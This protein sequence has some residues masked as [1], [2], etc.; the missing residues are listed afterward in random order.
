MRPING[1]IYNFIQQIWYFLEWVGNGLLFSAHKVKFV[2]LVYEYQ[3][4][5]DPVSLYADSFLT[6]ATRGP[7]C[8]S[9]LSWPIEKNHDMTHIFF[10]LI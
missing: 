6:L 5:S 7:I 3:A 1:D 4:G 2:A 10:G 8:H 9:D